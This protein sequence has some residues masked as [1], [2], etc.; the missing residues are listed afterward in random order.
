MQNRVRIPMEEISSEQV[1]EIK[2]KFGGS[3]YLVKV[4]IK[5]YAESEELLEWWKIYRSNGPF[6]HRMV[7]HAPTREIAL[8]GIEYLNGAKWK[9]YQTMPW[10]LS[11]EDKAQCKVFE[12]ELKKAK[13]QEDLDKIKRLAKEAVEKKKKAAA[14]KIRKEQKERIETIKRIGETERF[15][16]LEI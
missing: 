3:F 16:G 7:S 12:A 14:R 9:S 10:N 1:A 15:T 11:A 2:G 6:P 13:C 8:Q 4:M 5:P